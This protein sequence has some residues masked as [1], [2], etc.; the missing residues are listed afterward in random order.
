VM[1]TP[2]GNTDHIVA[3]VDSLNK[4]IKDQMHQ[5]VASKPCLCGNTKHTRL[6]QHDRYGLWHPTVVCRCCG[7][8]RNHPSLSQEF[9]TF[10][11]KSDSYRTLFEGEAFLEKARARFQQPNSI[12]RAIKKNG[13]LS[14]ISHVLEFGCGAGWNLAEFRVRGITVTG[15]ETNSTLAGIGKAHG[16]D[17]LSGSFD[18]L[19]SLNT[20]V[21]LLI[22]NHV[23]EHFDNPLAQLAE[24]LKKVSPG[25][26]I[27]I[28]V[29]NLDNF[30]IGQ[31]QIAHLYYFTPRVFLAYMET[32]NIDLIHFGHDGIHMFGIFRCNSTN[33][34][35]MSPALSLPRGEFKRIYKKYLAYR[36][37]AALSKLKQKLF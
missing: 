19:A 26:Y 7:L 14:E 28:G 30:D 3:D 18:T 12:F 29:P 1:Q 34:K 16:I 21:D 24:L 13:L 22:L 5:L 27:F 37:R 9:Y 11:Y 17:V 33:N 8:I 31:F 4:V 10:F 15:I 36:I 20:T 25:G 32:L 23:L 35:T 2:R 6:F